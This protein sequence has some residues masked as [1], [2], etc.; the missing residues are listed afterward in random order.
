[1][2]TGADFNMQIA[3]VGGTRHKIVAARAN[4]TDFVIC[5]M[6]SSLHDDVDLDSNRLILQEPAGIQQSSK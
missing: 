2:A 1:V 5:G 4:Y 6:D 3:L